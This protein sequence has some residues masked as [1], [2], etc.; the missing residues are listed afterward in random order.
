MV[1][2]KHCQRIQVN[3]N[4]AAMLRPYFVMAIPN[5]IALLAFPV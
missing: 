1:G 5:A 4:L 3:Q 2:A